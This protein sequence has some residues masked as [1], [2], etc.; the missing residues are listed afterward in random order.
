MNYFKIVLGKGNK[1]RNVAAEDGYIGIDYSIREDFSK[2]D[3]LDSVIKNKLFEITPDRSK[4][5]VGLAAGTISRFVNE[6]QIGDI[7]FISDTDKTYNLFEVTSD[8]YYSENKLFLHCRDVKFLKNIS[9]DSFPDRINNNLG[10]VQ[11]FTSVSNIDEKRMIDDV[12]GGRTDIV[13]IQEI[14]SDD[15]QIFKLEKEFESFVVKNWNQIKDFEGY[16][17]YEEGELYG[18]QFDTTKVGIIDILAINEKEKKFLVIELKRQTSDQVVGQILRYISFV[19]EN[20]A[21]KNGYSVE[22]LI[23]TEKLKDREQDYIN[24]SIKLLGFIRHKTYQIKFEL[25]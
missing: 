6:V 11:T 22:G 4:I 10:N 23:V 2:V 21:D 19:K 18:Q 20:L 5:S 7:I 9:K 16:K 1:N 24:Y 14:N 8:Y 3:D 13:K 12:L 15:N 17:I 25:I